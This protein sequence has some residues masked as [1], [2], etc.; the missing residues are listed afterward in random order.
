MENPA[1]E[2]KL[3]DNFFFLAY[4]CHAINVKLREMSHARI[5]Y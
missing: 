2:N 4:F 1:P 5:R 3:C